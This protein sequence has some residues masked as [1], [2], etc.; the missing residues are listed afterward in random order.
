MIINSN[1]QPR[2]LPSSKIP[3]LP[4]PLRRSDPSSPYCYCASLSPILNDEGELTSLSLPPG[5]NFL[6]TQVWPSSRSA[7][8][9]IEK[10]CNPNWTVCELGCG[11]G[12]PALTAASLGSR[13]IATD[14]DETALQMVQWAAEEQGFVNGNRFATEFFDLTAEDPLPNAD[15]YVLSDVFESAEI[16]GGT[17]WHVK[18]L[19]DAKNDRDAESGASRLWIF[20]Q[21]DRAQREVF[22][23][24]LREVKEFEHVEWTMNHKPDLDARICLFDL[25]EMDVQ[26]N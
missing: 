12:L 11:P 13:V 2:F 1:P 6:A 3:L 19:L 20:A 7:S 24:S 17:A 14:V 8:F 26:Y 9:V 4:V 15:L 21:S 18:Q 22:L 23:N 25:N 5:V 16:A 10:Y